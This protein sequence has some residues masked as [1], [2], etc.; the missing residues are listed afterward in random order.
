MVMSLAQQFPEFVRAD[1]PLAPLTTLRV[2][3]SAEYL[4]QPRTISDLVA[5]MQAAAERHLPVRVLGIGSNVL[6]SD[7]GVRGVIVRLCESG[8]T[9][10]RVEPP[11]VAAGSGTPLITLIREAASRGLAG[12][13]T[14]VG[15]AATV[16]G[17]LRVNAGDRSGEIG[18]YAR[19]VF[20]LDRHGQAV[21]RE[22]DDLK[23]GEKTSNLDDPVILSAEFE[24]ETDSPEAIVKRLRKSWILRQSR[25][26]YPHESSARLF[27]DPKGLS[28]TA[29]IDRAGLKEAKVGQARLSER[30]ANYVVTSPGATARDVS[31][32]IDL[33]RSKVRESS[34]ISLE[35][36]LQIW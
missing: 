18:Q 35:L 32:L 12:L 29:V 8:F 25:Q 5:L 2:G 13:E 1:A 17:A 24:L 33:V 27:R 15:I 9:H 16:G 21:W 30:N 19:R 4:A 28:A 14:L 7:D 6:I 20:V 11:R 22:H 36:D 23:F 34:G 26:P 31:R 3:G 10:V